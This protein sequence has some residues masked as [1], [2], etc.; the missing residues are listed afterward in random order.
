MVTEERD[1]NCMRK[2]GHSVLCAVLFLITLL[3]VVALGQAQA[4]ETPSGQDQTDST[5]STTMCCNVFLP[6]IQ[7]DGTEFAQQTE[8]DQISAANVTLTQI[9]SDPYTNSTSQH[10]TEV[11]PDTFAKGKG[12]RLHRSGA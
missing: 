11:E 10:A 7:A 8:T 5:D 12:V 3:P 6:L 2:L 1:R 4:Q 9:S